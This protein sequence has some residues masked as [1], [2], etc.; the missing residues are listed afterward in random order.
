MLKEDLPLRS[1]LILYILIGTIIV[2][3]TSSAITIN[4]VTAQEK[5]LAY[6][7]S[8]EMAENYATKF[9]RD[10]NSNMAIADTLSRTLEEY[11]SNNRTEVNNILEK[12]LS[13]NPHLIGTYVAFEPDAFDGKDEQYINY[14]R[15]HDQTGR[16]VPYWNKIGGSTKVEALLDYD[17]EDYYQLPKKEKQNILTEPY[18]YQGELIVSF[19]SPIMEND[20]FR[21]I[22]G[23][24]VS[25]NYIDEE[26]SNI[27]T[28]QTGYAFT[29]SNDGIFLSHPQHKEW[30]GSRRITDFTLPEIEKAMEDIKNGKKGHIKTI[31]PTNSKD[32]IMFYSPVRTGNFSFVLIIPEEEMFAGVNSLK[33]RL[34]QV[35]FIAIVFMGIIAIIISNSI[36]HP[37]SNIVSDFKTIADEAVKGNINIRAGEN[38]NPDF[39]PIPTGFNEILDKLQEANAQNEELQSIINSSPTIAFK[40][41][42]DNT[43]PVLFVS[44]NITR[45]GYTPEDFLTGDI[46]YGD[47]VHPDDLKTVQS[48][49]Q[50]QMNN[51]VDD[52]TTEYRIITRSGEIHWVDERTFIRYDENRNVQYLK[53]IVVD[54]TKRKIAEEGLVEA[55]LEAEQANRAK[56][57]FLASMSHELRTPLNSIIGFADII[58]ERIHGELTDKQHKYVTNI[59]DSGRHLLTLINNI[60]DLSKVESGKMEL[61]IEQFN[62]EDVIKGIKYNT[63]SL[64]SRKNIE[65]Q[66][67]IDPYIT[68]IDAD[69]IKFKQILYNLVSN[70]IKFTP[71][72][73]L[74]TIKAKLKDDMINLEVTDSGIGISEENI[75]RLFQPFSQIESQKQQEGTGLGLV[76]VKHFIEMHHGN[77]YVNSE[78]GK[79]STFG[80]NIPIKQEK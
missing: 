55:K 46:D 69:R 74:I 39:R 44:K 40:W 80:F 3:I 30:I 43:W 42:A 56:S 21:G 17:T 2:L 25:L 1:K 6:T 14:D 79:G 71:E 54:V 27:R 73:G 38:I 33:D 50:E 47:I 37:I 11:D 57:Q 22:G 45:F 18:L 49:L 52:F 53:G 28:F 16:F 34:I 59:S 12:L 63:H 72:N 15:A 20:T 76:L 24:D 64:T 23:V 60:L 58:L 13:E 62:P 32:I 9:D 10:M 75:S 19:V 70:A 78:I 26:V 77:I 48:R 61:S 8:I 4:M 41:K 66:T 51:K 36:S 31:D 7:Q 68:T 67:S 5:E 29:T 35:S 65:L